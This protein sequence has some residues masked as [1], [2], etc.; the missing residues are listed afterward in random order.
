MDPKQARNKKITENNDIFLDRRPEMYGVLTASNE[1]QA[2]IM[3]FDAA[4]LGS[5]HGRV[6]YGL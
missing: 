4:P 1:E 3:N 2:E 5:A 6:P